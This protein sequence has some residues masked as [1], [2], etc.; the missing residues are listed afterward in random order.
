[1]HSI[2]KEKQMLLDIAQKDFETNTEKNY[3]N[4]GFTDMETYYLDKSADHTD[5]L[6]EYEFQNPME[7]KKILESKWSDLS[8]QKMI[9]AILV[10]VF[11]LQNGTGKTD[12]ISEKIY[13]F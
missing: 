13:N 6:M 10:A 9:P 4:H 1:M 12:E 2:D 8:Q 7:L 3:L 11:K 5:R